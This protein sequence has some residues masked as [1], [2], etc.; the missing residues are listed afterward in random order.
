MIRFYVESLKDHPIANYVDSDIILEKTI[1]RE[2]IVC[3]ADEDNTDVD[4]LRQKLLS[5][6]QKA[7]YEVKRIILI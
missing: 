4:K 7:G 2:V 5:A 1:H 6:F 3:D